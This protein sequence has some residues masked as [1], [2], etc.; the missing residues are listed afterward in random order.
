MIPNRKLNLSTYQKN[1]QITCDSHMM[2][3]HK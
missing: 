2:E 3:Y 1:L